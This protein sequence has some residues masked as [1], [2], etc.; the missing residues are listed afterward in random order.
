MTE[1]S[2][3]MRGKAKIL[4]MTD[5]DKFLQPIDL[6]PGVKAFC[7]FRGEISVSPY[8]GFNVCHYTG[9]MP[10]H[11]DAS[12]RMLSQAIGL[13]LEAIVVPR[14]TH[15]VNC[16]TVKGI[17]VS[18]SDLEGVDGLVTDIKNVAIGVSTADCVPV[19][20]ADPTHGVIGVAHAGWRGAVGGVVQNTLVSMIQLGAVA[21][22]IVVRFGPS[23]M[24]CCFE[25]GEEVAA[26]F[27]ECNVVRRPGGRPHVDLQGYVVDV[28][29]REGVTDIVPSH[30]CTRCQPSRYFSARAL[31]IESGRIFSFLYLEED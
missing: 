16:M 18:A 7:T 22:D 15:S 21:S 25:V 11:V 2:G 14:Q 28:L 20:M 8:S 1:I 31:G 27:P 26:Y 12:R 10:E 23:I 6:A 29:K 4:T 9:D 3:M 13:P 30:E 17:P 5:K 24:S 19:L